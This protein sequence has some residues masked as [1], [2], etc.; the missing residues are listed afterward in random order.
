MGRML[1]TI[2]PLGLVAGCATPQTPSPRSPRRPLET[3]VWP[4]EKVKAK[5]FDWGERRL[6]PLTAET[7]GTKDTLVGDI[8]LKAAKE[9]RPPHPHAE[10][11]FLEIPEGEGP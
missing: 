11:E 1:G 6:C 7:Y 10:E 9:N 8:R 5:K 2:A 3:V 4:L